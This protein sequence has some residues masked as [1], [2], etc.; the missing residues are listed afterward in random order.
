MV[1]IYVMHQT[2][3]DSRPLLW[4]LYGIKAILIFPQFFL[5]NITSRDLLRV[6]DG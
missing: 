6:D 1:K 4:L 2:Y 3:F 5:H